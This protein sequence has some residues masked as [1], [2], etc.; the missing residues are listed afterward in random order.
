MKI[1]V[2]TTSTVNAT[3][4]RIEV[5]LR[6]W[7]EDDERERL[8]GLPGVVEEPNGEYLAHLVLTLDL[9]TRKVRDWPAGRTGAADYTTIKVCDEGTYIL[10]GRDAFTVGPDTEITRI[11]EYVPDCIPS[12]YGDYVS[13][14]VLPDGTILDEAGGLWIPDPCKVAEAFFPQPRRR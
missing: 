6:Y 4:I 13:L 11:E 14:Q 1:T 2:P 8:Q 3:A 5:P 9:E 10:L 12:E 7:D